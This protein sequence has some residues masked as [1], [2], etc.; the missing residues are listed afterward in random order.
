MM[1]HIS[2]I[3]LALA[4]LLLLGTIRRYNR[5]MFLLGV[6]TGVLIVQY[7][8]FIFE[9]LTGRRDYSLV[10]NAA[11]AMLYLPLFSVFPYVLRRN[12]RMI[13]IW[14]VI[15][16]CIF[17][18]FVWCYYEMFILRSM[19]AYSLSNLIWHAE[20]VS[21]AIVG[22]NLWSSFARAETRSRL[23]HHI[24]WLAG[25]CIMVVLSPY[26]V[27]L[28]SYTFPPDNFL[29]PYPEVIPPEKSTSVL[30]MVLLLLLVYRLLVFKGIMEK[31]RLLKES[32][33]LKYKMKSNE[34]GIPKTV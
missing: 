19:A 27:Q 18:L 31:S 25:I 20:V 3:I 34:R 22:Q 21:I 1:L 24:V 11:F 23:H 8:H 33:R 13:A 26:I 29:I 12:K 32:R 4:I 16:I 17:S 6:I 7:L 28:A 30:T 14:F 2:V 10:V 9:A 5:E 15:G